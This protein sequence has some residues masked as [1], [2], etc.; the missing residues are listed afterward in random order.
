[1]RSIV[2]FALVALGCG[3]S[4]GPDDMPPDPKGW[5]ITVDMSPLDRYVAPETETS[6]TVKGKATATEGLASIEI[7]GAAA[8]FADDG[9][10]MHSVAVM[11]GLTRVPILVKDQAGHERKG[12]RTL[13]AAK[14]LAD[15]AHNAGAA[16]LVLDDAILASM[17]AGIASQA[18]TVDVAGEIL[19]RDVLSQDDRCVT[20][21]TAAT[22]GTVAVEL[23]ED[24]GDLWLHITIPNLDVRFGGQC[25]GIFSQIPIAGRMGGS[26]HVWSRLTAKPP[27]NGACIDSFTHTTP[28]VQVTGWQFGVWGVGGPLQNWIVDLFSGEKSA[29]A[30]AQIATEVRGRANTLLAEKLQSIS[31]FDRTSDLELLG[32]PVSLHLCLGGLEKIGEQ[33]VARVAAS[34]AGLGGTRE[35]PGAP[36]IDGAALNPAA[37]ELVLDGNLIAQLLYASWRDGG[38]A[39]NANDVDIGVLQ[40]LM[41][42]IV[43][44][45]PNA[46]TAQVTI[47]AELPPLVRARTSGANDLTIELG[48]LMVDLSVEGTR[49]LRFNVGL[50][51]VLDLI[52]TDGKLTPKVVDTMAEVALIDELYDG[53]D[54]ALEQAVGSQIGGAAAGLLGDS[55]AIAL[56]DLPGLGAPVD[57]TPDAG[58]RF[59]RIE[60]Q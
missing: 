30:R 39:P 45:W 46:T 49:I 8:S 11:P 60:L 35:A 27:A 22:Q 9:A 48:D 42:P 4:K 52:P 51:L 54:G 24:A 29:E 33:L 32:K 3:S 34:A 1:M 12:T 40:I 43:D 31:V 20:W 57:V 44:R 55:A 37:K 7:A 13:M 16:S 23:V 26:I 14:F 6:W 47:D 15:G 10:F 41:P 59:L 50:T 25:Q 53:V 19:A 28:E 56:P 2:W 17:S 38:L 5:T 18:G 36:L 58:G 21:P